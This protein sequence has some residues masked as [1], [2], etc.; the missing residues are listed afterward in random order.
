MVDKE[1]VLNRAIASNGEIGQLNKSIEELAEL[2]T[3]IQKYTHSMSDKDREHVSEEM[4]DVQI[5]LEQMLKM[6]IIDDKMFY[7]FM[8]FKIKRLDNRLK[9]KEVIISE[10]SNEKEN[11]EYKRFISEQR[12]RELC[13][14]GSGS[15]RRKCKKLVKKRRKKQR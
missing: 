2:I 13:E 7:V 11:E 3:A 4:A 12:N 5:M 15:I 10:Q 8:D 1:D 9:N 14:C 6:D